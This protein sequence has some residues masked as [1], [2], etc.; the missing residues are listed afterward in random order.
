MRHSTCVGVTV[1]TS[2]DVLN[3]YMRQAAREVVSF[4][5]CKNVGDSSDNNIMYTAIQIYC[6]IMVYICALL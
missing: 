6:T 3:L 2:G 5:I 4:T 1:V